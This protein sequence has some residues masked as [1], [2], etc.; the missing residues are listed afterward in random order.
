MAR[1][2][3]QKALSQAG[4]A[5]RRAV[6][7]MVL[8]GRV[9][10][11]GEQVRELPCFVDLAADEVRLDGTRVRAP[12]SRKVYF[13]LN[14]PR[15]VACTQHDPQ[16]RPRAVDLIP[17]IGE[18]VYCVGRLDIE[19]TGLILLTND[20]ELTQHLTHPS[21]GVVKRYVAEV[22]GR[23]T[24]EAIAA[25]KAGT[26]LDGRRTRPAVVKVL[27]RSNK[28]SLLEIGLSEGRNREIRRVLARL[29]HRV[30]RLKRV[31]IGPV[32]DKGLKVG[33][34]RRLRA[35]EV[36]ALRRCG[37]GRKAR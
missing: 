27:R 8:E 14:K 21:S 16:G 23:P 34:Y 33:G 6:E 28:R 30:R 37:R 25:L 7:Q 3:I 15:G 29:G 19:S 4:A 22:D 20:G 35:A 26:Y 17:P 10:V 32:T 1:M 2:R 5:S 9:S 13:L 36:A 18:R 31:A 24:A 11:N 12:S